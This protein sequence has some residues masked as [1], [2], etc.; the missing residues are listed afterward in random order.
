M[1]EAPIIETSDVVDPADAAVLSA[2]LDEYADFYRRNGWRA[3]GEV[4]CD[5]P[6]TGRVFFTKEP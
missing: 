1:T 4:P 2:G 6:G 5:P 3:F